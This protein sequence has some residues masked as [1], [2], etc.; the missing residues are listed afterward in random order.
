[1]KSLEKNYATASAADVG[2]KIGTETVAVV[3]ISVVIASVF[4]CLLSLFL[5]CLLVNY[6]PAALCLVDWQSVRVYQSDTCASANI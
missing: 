4:S 6:S 1:M 5:F 3:V 2:G